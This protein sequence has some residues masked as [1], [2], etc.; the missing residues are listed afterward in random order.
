MAIPVVLMSSHPFKKVRQT[1]PGELIVTNDLYSEGGSIRITYYLE[2]EN[3][4]LN[5]IHSWMLLLE[6]KHGAPID[7][8]EIVVSP[9]MP[10]HLHGMLTKAE[11]HK[12]DEPGMYRVDGMKFHMP[13]WWEIT[14][15]VSTSKTR[16]LVRFQLIIGENM[17]VN[18]NHNHH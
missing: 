13:G 2:G 12:L 6:D 17:N 18:A 11:V 16:D 14:M 3:A 1:R 7:D 15:D 5:D 4:P 10:E 8:A 9:D